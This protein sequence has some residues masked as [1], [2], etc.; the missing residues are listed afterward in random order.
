MRALDLTRI[1]QHRSLIPLAK[2][3]PRRPLRLSAK[4]DGS[5]QLRDPLRLRRRWR[6]PVNRRIETVV[7]ACDPVITDLFFFSREFRRVFLS[8]PRTAELVD[9]ASAVRPAIRFPLLSQDRWER[10]PSLF[11]PFPGA[12]TCS[13]E[14]RGTAAFS[15][16]PMRRVRGIPG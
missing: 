1:P 9:S 8:A 3:R 16:R 6:G 10:T 15:G 2:H 12:R 11:S 14:G 13:P 7:R 4:P 5:R